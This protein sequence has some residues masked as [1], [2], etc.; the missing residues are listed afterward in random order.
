MRPHVGEVSGRLP[1]RV[2]PLTPAIPHLC[3]RK[4][5]ATYEVADRCRWAMGMRGGGDGTI[6]WCDGCQAWHVRWR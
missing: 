1:L 6:L 5:Y 3:L 4:Q 2:N